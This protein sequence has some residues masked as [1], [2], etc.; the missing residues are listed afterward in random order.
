MAPREQVLCVEEGE[1][2]VIDLGSLDLFKESKDEVG[3]KQPKQKQEVLLTAFKTGANDEDDEI[4]EEKEIEG[5]NANNNTL[6]LNDVVDEK[7][8]K[9]GSWK[10]RE[11]KKVET[12]EEDTNVEIERVTMEETMWEEKMEVLLPKRN[13]KKGFLKMIIEKWT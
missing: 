13:E 11:V 3:T 4:K 12:E 6:N 7:M 8:H 9:G 2:E 10:G 1:G 5:K